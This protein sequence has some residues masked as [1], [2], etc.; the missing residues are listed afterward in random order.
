MVTVDPRIAYGHLPENAAWWRIRQVL[1]GAD[2]GQVGGPRQLAEVLFGVSSKPLGAIAYEALRTGRA[3]DVALLAGLVRHPD[4][5]LLEPD[6]AARVLSATANGPGAAFFEVT[7]PRDWS[8]GAELLAQIEPRHRE[9]VLTDLLGMLPD[10]VTPELARVWATDPGM[11]TWLAE[12]GSWTVVDAA[13]DTAFATGQ[14]LTGFAK[15]LR[16]RDIIAACRA[17]DHDALAVAARIPELREGAL[18]GYAHA[19]WQA[20]SELVEQ[21][22]GGS[23]SLAREFAAL[24]QHDPSRAAE[25]VSAMIADTS[26]RIRRVALDGDF[27]YARQSAIDAPLIAMAKRD[28][29]RAADLFAV[30]LTD[31]AAAVHLCAAET[32]HVLAS[33]IPGRA[34]DLF[35]IALAHPDPTVR[36][37]SI[38][39]HGDFYSDT[40]RPLATLIETVPDR[41]VELVAAVLTD[42]D[43]QVRRSAFAVLGDLAVVVPD[44]TVELVS[45]ALAVPGNPAVDYDAAEA[46]CV[47]ARCLPTLARSAPG[48]ARELVLRTLVDADDAVRGPAASALGALA[49]EESDRIVGLIAAALTDS[50][51]IVRGN[52]AIGLADLAVHDPARAAE[53]VADVLSDPEV[54][55]RKAF[56]WSSGED[57]DVG[58]DQ[59]PMSALGAIASA[60]PERAVELFVAAL[61]DEDYDVG[62]TAVSGL[63]ELCERD[64]RRGGDLLAGLLARPEDLVRLDAATVLSDLAEADP[65]R[66]ADLLADAFADP[67]TTV[68]MAAA[69]ALYALSGRM[70]ARAI[71][72]LAAALSDVS[73]DVRHSALGELGPL[74]GRA[75]QLA[76]DLLGSLL[77]HPERGLRVAAAH[78]LGNIAAHERA[79]DLFA[80]ALS[81][82]GADVRRVAAT[83]LRLMASHA[84][85][86]SVDLVGVAL[87]DTEV[88]VRRAASSTLG[89]LVRSAPERAVDPVAAA[90]ASD[91]NDLRCAAAAE[92]GILADRLPARTAPL[93]VAALSDPLGEVRVEAV[94]SLVGVGS[95]DPTLAASLVH[96]ALRDEVYLVREA[97]EQCLPGLAAAGCDLRRAVGGLTLDPEIVLSAAAA[98]SPMRDPVPSALI[99]ALRAVQTDTGA[100]A[101]LRHVSRGRQLLQLAQRFSYPPEILEPLDGKSVVSDGQTLSTRVI[102]SLAEL[103]Q[104]ASAMGNCTAG[105]GEVLRRGHVIVAASGP[106]GRPVVNAY[107]RPG[108]Q[109][110]SVSEVNGRLN[111]ET[112]ACTSVRE[113]LSTQLHALPSPSD[114]P[115]AGRSPD[116][117]DGF[118]VNVEGRDVG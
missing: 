42:P 21:D 51:S 28:P 106:D 61:T 63:Q 72:L 4:E 91:D 53:L 46:R 7:D 11:L 105:Y 87:S 16:G 89:A 96:T 82:S 67:S 98:G 15:T 57:Y 30:A 62:E 27:D 45:A 79:A 90:L 117:I 54:E 25:I 36:L 50:S 1:S 31:P 49:G 29:A 69:R 68:R 22:P 34:V 52:A 6:V 112:A 118:G 17:G 20:C 3:R 8:A 55:V 77:E 99:D 80:V 109:G 113:W 39:P 66:A 44:A 64:P 43:S 108:P 12:Q 58:D 65:D 88:D 78:A 37:G 75:P 38:R 101:D 32:L 110:W 92:L 48:A 85:E 107:L 73:D 114:P 76:S 71:E 10:G 41:V 23:H 116:G 35:A 83:R 84:P 74:V 5:P 60:V 2:M 94:K 19:L 59:R 103:E 9:R 111:R 14:D 40:P 104:N 93:V 95:V 70:P 56:V 26:S 81:D 102:R 13:F 18:D 97:A 100:A 86:R 47:A 115:S 33:L 24:Q